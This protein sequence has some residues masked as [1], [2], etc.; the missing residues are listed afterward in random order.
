MVGNRN[1]NR[2]VGQHFL[3]N[4]MAAAPA[5]FGKALLGQDLTDL[6]P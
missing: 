4:D 6:F 2:V 5:N 1:G 3:H